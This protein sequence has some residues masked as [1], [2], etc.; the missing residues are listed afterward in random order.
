MSTIPPS[1]N[2]NITAA[3]GRPAGTDRGPYGYPEGLMNLIKESSN[4]T[5]LTNQK[6]NQKFVTQEK[7]DPKKALH[8]ELPQKNPSPATAAANKN[9]TNPKAPESEG[10]GRIYDQ[11]CAA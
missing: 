1:N 7:N 6:T 9:S 2:N 10:P 11:G 3:N 5:K 4:N 8:N